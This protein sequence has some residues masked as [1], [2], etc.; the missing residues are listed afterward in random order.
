MGF[1]ITLG[2]S[3]AKHGASFFFLAPLDRDEVHGTSSPDHGSV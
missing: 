2:P 3:L 1:E